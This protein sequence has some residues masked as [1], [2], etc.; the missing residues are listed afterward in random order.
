[1]EKNKMKRTLK[2]LIVTLLLA[3]CSLSIVACGKNKVK[4]DISVKEDAMPQS[5]F[6]LGEDI[7]LSA[8]V[9]L[10]DNNGKT[11]E[12][13]MNSEDVTVTGYDKNTLGQQTITVSYKDKSVELTVNVVERMQISDHIADYLVGDSLD[14]SKGRVKITRNDGSNYTVMLKSDKVSVTGFTSETAGQK[15]VTVKY[16]SGS[17]TYTTTLSLNVHNVEKVELTRPTKITYNSHDSGVEVAGGILTLSA[18]NGKISKDVTVTADMISGFDLTAVNKTNSPLTQTVSVM[19]DGKAY[20]YDIRITYTP[21]SEFKNNAGVVAG[22]DWTK[23]EA[24]EISREQGETAMR[25]MELYLDM[26]PAEQTLL[27][28]EETLNMARTAIVYAFELW[29]ND[30]LEFDGAF[31]VSDGEF[32]LQAKDEESIAKAVELLEDTDRPLFTLYELI[33]G[34]VNTFGTEENDETV[35]EGVY[36]SYYPTFDPELF[37]ELAD[38]FEYML[39]LDALM[40]AVGTDWKSNINEYSDEIE[41]VYDS[42]I[43]GDYYSYEYAQFFIY[44]SLWREGDDA[45]DFL[46]HYYFDILGD[47]ESVIMIANLRLPSKLEEIFVY[48]YEAMNQLEYIASYYTADTSQ[49]FYN[50]YMAVDLSNQ[51]LL[52][53]DPD[54]AMLKV[55]FQGLPLNS[56]LGIGTE[57]GLYTF[58]DMIDYLC[59]TEGG[60][61]S[62]CGA[63]LGN[64]EFEALFDKYLYILITLFDN[65][66][67][68]ELGNAINN[69]EGTPEYIAD[70]KEMLALYMQLT[71]SE[72]FFFIGTLNAYYAMNIPPYAFDTESEYADFIAVFFDMLNDTYMDMFETNAGKDAYLALMLA[73]EAYAQ[74]YNTENWL[75]EMTNCLGYIKN[76]LAGTEMSENDK[77]LF[78]SELG[79]IYTKYTALLPAENGTE[80]TPVDLGEWADEFEELNEAIV[81]LELAYALINEG[82]TYYSLFF[83]AYERVQAIADSILNSDAPDYIKDYFI[84]AEAYSLSTLD[85]LLDPELV[86][87]DE[88]F[89][90]YDYVITFYRAIYINALVAFSDGVFD[91]YM[92]GALPAFMANAY[93]LY[94]NYYLWDKGIDAARIAEILA[95]F[96]TLTPDEQ[97][98]FL[99]Y[100]E[101]EE[102]LYYTALEQFLN[103]NYE[104]D[105]IISAISALFEVEMQYVM[106][107]YYYEYYY[108]Y[109]ESEQITREEFEEIVAQILPD[110]ND[111]YTAFLDTYKELGADEALFTEDFGAMYE[112]Y[113]SIVEELNAEYSGVVA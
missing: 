95:S 52:S 28:R 26:S 2:I 38:V 81:N 10:I 27:T 41:A 35:Y 101:G 14:L 70:I 46:Y 23:E 40:D 111:A 88:Q 97:V 20:T 25:M 113:K 7:D 87:E 36:F 86:V 33:Y 3:I 37:E 55:L 18:L 47:A 62:L 107:G 63:L 45:F 72:Q 29:G 24:P 19:Y 102:G 58:I 44:V 92:D 22:L 60:Y 77:A 61:Y 100:F 32:V 110:L 79:S 31:T 80:E 104:S 15:N 85:K 17:E 112:Y 39:E 78:M 56:M 83:S 94:W 51:L 12:V 99:F 49:F 30:V 71:P 57:D 6:V 64:P 1:M 91:Y 16:T 105:A 54:D 75:E 93:D 5:V 76:A 42:I 59:T 13:P 96:R 21:V 4:G 11:T 53:E 109:Y 68:D 74:R 106:F 73:T 103:D 8:G 66:S 98:I 90:S 9:L 89:W 108:S 43:N 65:Y 82:A 48:I 69:Y 67:E 34:I 84:Y 50:Y